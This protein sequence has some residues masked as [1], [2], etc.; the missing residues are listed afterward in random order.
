MI[1]MM[2]LNDKLRRCAAGYK[3]TKSQEKISYLIYMD[4]I[5]L[6]AKKE[7]ELETLIHAVRIYS[8]NIGMEFVIEKCTM[9]VMR[10][11]KRH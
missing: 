5:E 6:S 10:S 3:T 1:A 11:G 2:P 8:E 4:D 7:K 9:L